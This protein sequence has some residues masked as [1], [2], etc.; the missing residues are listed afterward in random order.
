M[1]KNPIKK[2]AREFS[3]QTTDGLTIRGYDYGDRLSNKVPIVCLPGLTRSTRD[4]EAIAEHLS[5]DEQSPRRI[6][7]LDYRGRGRSDYD[8]K[9]KNYNVLVEAQDVLNAIVAAGLKDVAILGTSRGGI[10]AMLLGSMRP[11][12]LSGVI[13]HDIG[14]TVDLAGLL[15]IKNYIS[16]I[17]SPKDW[18][19]AASMLKTVH[20]RRFPKFKEKDWKALAHLTFK[21]KNH[22]P[23]IDFDP[24]LVKT[25]ES[26]S[27]DDPP[28]NLWPQFMSLRSIPLL[29]IKGALSDLLTQETF[30]DMDRAHPTMRSVIVPDEGH[31]PSLMNE[32]VLTEIKAL[33]ARLD[34]T[35]HK[36]H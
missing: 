6:L 30:E 3:C 25:L 22:L 32:E 19:E 1:S 13:L 16:H 31:V 2:I 5:G 24:K 21:N 7:T 28:P 26:I 11:G 14:P 33:M 8:K 29:V 17:R 9:W 23:A 10:I 35:H 15:K 34:K 12:I 27:A 36:N 20:Q 4:F 18:L